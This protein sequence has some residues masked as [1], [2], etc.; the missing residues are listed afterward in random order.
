MK[1]GVAET[2]LRENS[3]LPCVLQT[4]GQ[5]EGKSLGHW[6]NGEG[7]GLNLCQ[8]DGRAFSKFGTMIR[9]FALLSPPRSQGFKTINQKSLWPSFRPETNPKAAKR[10]V[11]RQRR[12]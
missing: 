8:E 2:C 12:T 11:T 9:F 1:C 4:R 6:V 10:G 7:A 5:A 3:A